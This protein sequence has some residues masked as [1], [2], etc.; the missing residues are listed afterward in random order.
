MKRLAAAPRVR[1]AVVAAARAVGPDGL[2]GLTSGGL[3]AS[4]VWAL[5]GWPWACL[6]LGVP[7]GAFYLWAEGRKLGKVEE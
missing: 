1:A 7:L 3:V 2:L 6:A 4:G 5:Y